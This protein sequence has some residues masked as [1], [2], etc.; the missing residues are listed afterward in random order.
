M[1]NQNARALENTFGWARIEILTM[2]IVC[3]FLASFCFSI[4]V[5][6]I[7][8]FVHLG[9]NDHVNHEGFH[10]YTYEICIVLASLGLVLNGI[11][12]LLIGGYTFHQGSFLHLTPDGNVYIVDRGV[13][14]KTKND[15]NQQ[16]KLKKKSQVIHELARDACSAVM[17][18]VVSIIFVIFDGQ[19]T[20]SFRLLD[21][22]AALVSITILMKLSIPYSKLTIFILNNLI[23]KFDFT[24]KEA[25]MILLQTVPF[26][27]DID[28]FEKE[29]LQKFPDIQSIHELHLWELSHSKYVATAHMIFEN[30]TTF[31]KNIEEIIDY[32]HEQDINIVT[33]QPEFKICGCSTKASTSIESSLV[34]S[35]EDLCLVACRETC[36]EKLCCQRKTSS[37]SS[38]DLHGKCDGS[39]HGNLEQ[40]ISVRNVS[41]EELNSVSLSTTIE[42]IN[43]I[44]PPK[45][46]LHKTVSVTEPDHS[47]A[48]ASKSKSDASDIHLVSFSRVVSES[49]IKSD[50]HDE[51][52]KTASEI[53]VENRLLQQTAN[54]D[55]NKETED[56]HA[57]FDS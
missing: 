7:Q 13:D 38:L 45:S 10:T 56:I 28:N 27:I 47:K 40:V 51:V 15:P 17:V 16:R 57:K 2:V 49:A 12:Y 24:V 20:L 52:G 41:T 36:E 4:V 35:E 18:M 9:H 39:S 1:R 46:K 54:T 29:I 53:L 42:S 22:I 8:T 37:N 32:F 44:T 26:S 11:S 33:I 25:G 48:R 14:D 5:E 21:P 19:N 50:E 55:N 34:V 43:K 23:L 6:V 31:Q 3:T 30:P